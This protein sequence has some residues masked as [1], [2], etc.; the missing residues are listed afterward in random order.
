MFD[1]GILQ[2][3]LGLSIADLLIEDDLETINKGAIAELFVGLELLKN[4]SP[5]ESAMLY[6]WQRDAR[7]SQA[8]VDFVIQK[9]AQII[10]IEVKAGRKGSMQS[11]YLFLKEKDL[12]EG[13]RLSLE[14][15]SS[16]DQIK[17]Y[18]LYAVK[19]I[20]QNT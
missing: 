11:M 4:T 6:Y 1:T 8:E 13:I 7:N 18:P 17:I 12:P 16:F 20:F 9:Q 10:P 2:R 19:N 3:I 14:N 15:F 5:Y